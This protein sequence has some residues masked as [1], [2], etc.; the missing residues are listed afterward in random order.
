M[1]LAVAGIA[2]VLR[3]INYTS[4]PSPS[5]NRDELA[6]AWAGQSLIKDY[7]PSSWSYLSAYR[8]AGVQA[9][10]DGTLLPYVHHWLD[11]PPL[12]AL[13]VGGVS[14]M[15]GQGTP[16]SVT[17][18]WIRLVPIV[19]SVMTLLL[20][21]LWARPILGRWV[22]LPFLI[23]AFS[24]WAVEMSHS[25][26]A[27]ALLAPLFLG[28]LLLV[29]RRE[30]WSLFLLGV[31]CMCLPLVKLAGLALGAGVAL[32]A[33]TQ[34]STLQAL[35]AT[36]GTIVGAVAYGAYGYWVSGTTLRD[37]W[38]AQSPRHGTFFGGFWE[39][40]QSG[41]ASLGGFV[42]LHDPVWYIGIASLVLGGIVGR[43]R[44]PLVLLAVVGIYAG[45]IAL[46][47]PSHIDPNGKSELDFNS[48]WYRMAVYPIVVSGPAVLLRELWS[49]SLATWI[50]RL[51]PQ[52]N[53]GYAPA[54]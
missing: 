6:W 29:G 39:F 49:V 23:Y 28:S 41:H 2:L 47:G 31:S 52:L 5:Q 12:F 24:P 37:V 26:E 33:L 13:L 16:E 45:A 40:V 4:F 43:K 20:L 34:R 30:K 27:E 1:L 8:D 9:T 42:P 35:A 11:H 10:Y 15:S 21:F 3:L 25:V 50:R 32:V 36:T 44:S 54:G 18:A 38:L 51:L 17:S 22:W 53:D 7:T 48:G 46:G 14:V 19:L